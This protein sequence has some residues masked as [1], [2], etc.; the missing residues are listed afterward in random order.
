MGHESRLHAWDEI[1]DGSRLFIKVSEGEYAVTGD[2]VL[3][4]PGQPPTKLSLSFEHL[5]RKEF[6][7]P[8]AT[9]TF[10]R[11]VITITYLRPEPTT[12]FVR[13]NVIRP[14][15]STHQRTFE[16]EYEGALGGSSAEDEVTLLALGEEAS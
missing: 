6:A 16:C 14:D 5:A 12:A 2:G 3:R 1:P 13:A 7:V 9:G 10:F 8:I 15:G 4:V 11:L